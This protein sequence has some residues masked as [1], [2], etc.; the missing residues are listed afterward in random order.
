MTATAEHCWAV[1]GNFDVAELAGKPLYRFD[2]APV[3][4]RCEGSLRSPGRLRLTCEQHVAR[5]APAEIVLF[6]DFGFF[7]SVR[8]CRGAAADSIAQSINLALLKLFFG[9]DSLPAE[10]LAPLFRAADTN[11]IRVA[12]EVCVAAA[13][14]RTPVAPVI[15]RVETD[16]LA[17]LA[18]SGIP[19][20]EGLRLGFQPVYDLRRGAASTYLCTPFRPAEEMP[21]SLSAVDPRDRPSLDEAML[22][23]SLKLT[24]D[25]AAAHRTAAAATPVSFE[26]LASPRGRRLYQLALKS[27][28]AAANPLIVVKI[29][30]VPQGTPAARLAEIV[31]T[32]RPYARRI[33]VQLPGADMRLNEAGQLGATGVFAALPQDCGSS[34]ALALARMLVRAAE[35]QHACC[36]MENV[37]NAALLGVVRSAGVRLASGAAFGRPGRCRT[38][39]DVLETLARAATQAA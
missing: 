35:M 11:E 28:D 29:E 24:R 26:T 17:R 18:A 6:Q 16:P 1:D 20:Y 12:G 39:P 7:L 19:G 2:L 13:P 10:Q 31:A 4:D 36:Y 14:P 9:T 23:H 32:I 8:S 25:I 22:D 37:R 33:F 27:A 5:L 21:A 3:L 34:A 15:A 38:A 30:D